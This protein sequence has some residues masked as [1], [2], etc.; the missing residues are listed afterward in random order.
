MGQTEAVPPPTD[1]V[2]VREM[3]S[4]C[5][6]PGAPWSGRAPLSEPYARIVITLWASWSSG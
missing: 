6:Q 4:F 5:F 2:L 1:A 3:A